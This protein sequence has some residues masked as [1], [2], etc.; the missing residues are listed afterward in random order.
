MAFFMSKNYVGLI[1]SP[2]HAKQRCF[3]FFKS[4]N[5]K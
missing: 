3:L 1:K 2:N 5:R 4:V